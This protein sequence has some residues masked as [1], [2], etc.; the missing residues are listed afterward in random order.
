[1]PSL[2]PVLF[3]LMCSVLERLFFFKDMHALLISLQAEKNKK[4]KEALC[5]RK[6]FL[7][8]FIHQSVPKPE[9][10]EELF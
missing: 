9:Y 2:L 6:S 8:A 7:V 10:P 5:Q 4:N 1:M 3:V